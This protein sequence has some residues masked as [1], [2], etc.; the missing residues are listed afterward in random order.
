VGELDAITDMEKQQ[1]EEV[2]Y[3]FTLVTGPR[4]FLSLTLSDT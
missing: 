2:R 4:R 1:H 3:F